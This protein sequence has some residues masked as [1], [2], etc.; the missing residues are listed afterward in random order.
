MQ[1]NKTIP[2][3]SMAAE[4]LLAANEWVFYQRNKR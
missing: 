2:R 4:A 3:E 1:S